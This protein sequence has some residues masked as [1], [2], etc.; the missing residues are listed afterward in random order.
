MLTAERIKARAK[1]LGFDLCGIA[2]AASYPELQFLDDWLARC[3][4]VV[5]KYQPQVFWFDWWI[6]QAVFEPYLQKFAAYYY[7]RA[8][9]WGKPAWRLYK[10]SLLYLALLFA[11]MVVDRVV[12]T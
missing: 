10:F 5:D 3:C 12:L 1:E 8:A 11:A 7:N 4:E 9:E 2:P 6:E